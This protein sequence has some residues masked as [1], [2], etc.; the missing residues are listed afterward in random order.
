ML[1]LIYIHVYINSSSGSRKVYLLL[2]EL[3]GTY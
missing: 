2:R 3:E 1:L